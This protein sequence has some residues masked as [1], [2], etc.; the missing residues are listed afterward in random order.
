MLTN[1]EPFC[2]NIPPTHGSGEVLT[3][4]YVI[5]GISP[6]NT[7]FTA[8][9]KGKE[10]ERLKNI[11]SGRAVMKLENRKDV[12]AC[13]STA[14]NKVKKINFMITHSLGD[15]EKASPD[16]VEGIGQALEELQDRLEFISMQI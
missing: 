8:T 15:D 7:I 5:S 11:D 10:L 3:V 14:E 9:Q 1:K 6:K 13:W 16:T 4:E 2:I 12:Q